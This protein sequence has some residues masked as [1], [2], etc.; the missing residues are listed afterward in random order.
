MKFVFAIIIIY[1]FFFLDSWYVQP[2]FTINLYCDGVL[3]RCM[4]CRT[5]VG[6][7]LE[8]GSYFLNCVGLVR[9]RQVIF[10]TELRFHVL[11]D[12]HLMPIERNVNDYVDQSLLEPILVEPSMESN[13]LALRNIR[14]E[15]QIEVLDDITL[16][17]SDGMAFE[18]DVVE[19]I[20]PYGES[21]VSMNDDSVDMNLN[22]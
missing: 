13:A 9:S 19:E 20:I 15:A 2:D 7:V 3:L 6:S 5:I 18:E 4:N 14:P 17:E 22:L 11:M 1:F 16:R 21:E 10:P 8:D 12:N